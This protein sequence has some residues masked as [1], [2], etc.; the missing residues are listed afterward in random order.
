MKFRP[1]FR[2]RFKKVC[3]KI[4]PFADVHDST[5]PTDFANH[6]ANQGLRALSLS[7]KIFIMGQPLWAASW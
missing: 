1:F 2:D 6:L 5:A 3:N 4:E 7:K